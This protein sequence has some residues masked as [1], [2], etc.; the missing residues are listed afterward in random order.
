MSASLWHHPACCKL[1]R[2]CSWLHFLVILWLLIFNICN[3]LCHVSCSCSCV[4]HFQK[5]MFFK[6]LFFSHSVREILLPMYHY[7]G[8]Q[9]S[10]K[11]SKGDKNERNATFHD[12]VAYALCASLWTFNNHETRSSMLLKISTSLL[13]MNQNHFFIVGS[14]DFGVR[15]DNSGYIVCMDEKREP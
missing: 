1:S 12:P 9:C 3:K 8:L 6:A 5:S 14:C 2:L 4:F 11:L 7:D 13:L 15:G 10:G